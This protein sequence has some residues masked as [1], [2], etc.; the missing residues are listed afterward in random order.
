MF[1]IVFDE[2]ILYPGQSVFS[3]NIG[4]HLRNWNEFDKSLL[5]LVVVDENGEILWGTPWNGS[6]VVLNQEYANVQR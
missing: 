4:I 5:G 1:E 3:G 6:G 2:H